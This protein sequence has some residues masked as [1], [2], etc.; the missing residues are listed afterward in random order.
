M[1][2]VWCSSKCKQLRP[3]V[4]IVRGGATDSGLATLGCL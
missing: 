1:C 4:E 3:R 2:L